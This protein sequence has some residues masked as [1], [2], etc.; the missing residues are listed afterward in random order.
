MKKEE[1]LRNWLEGL[2]DWPND[3]ELEGVVSIL[4][5]LEPETKHILAYYKETGEVLKPEGDFPT[6][7]QI[8]HAH[9]QMTN[10]AIICTYDSLL[11]FDLKRP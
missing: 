1:Q 8:K 4:S 2:Y 7:E 11:K 10:I 9:P 5:K 3:K 6:P